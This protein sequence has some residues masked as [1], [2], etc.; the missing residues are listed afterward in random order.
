M[1]GAGGSQDEISDA[2]PVSLPDLFQGGAFEN[3]NEPENTHASNHPQEAGKNLLRSWAT[4][5]QSISCSCVIP[6]SSN[7]QLGV[8]ASAPNFPLKFAE[9][10]SRRVE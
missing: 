7:A 4:R 1:K 10:N 8:V 6:C 3:S 9:T 5:S 2:T